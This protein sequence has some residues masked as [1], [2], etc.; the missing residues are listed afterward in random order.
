MDDHSI[1][2]RKFNQEI[3]AAPGDASYHLTAQAPREARG[4]WLTQVRAIEANARKTRAGHGSIERFPHAL[5][6]W[7]LRHQSLI[8]SLLG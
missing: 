4:K 3:F 6:F 8:V 5:D 2:T 1:A 7:K